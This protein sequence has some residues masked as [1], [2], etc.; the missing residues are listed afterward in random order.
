[1][2]YSR[3]PDPFR[4][5]RAG[6]LYGSLIAESLSLGVHWIYDPAEIVRRHG[7]VTDFIAPGADSYHPKKQAG[8]Q[9]H[10]GDQVLRLM[11]FLHR[12]QHWNA[13]NFL[14]DWRA[15]W[16]GYEDYFDKA[17]KATLANL[18][19]G[20][21]I[22]TCGSASDELAGPAR[23][24]PLAAFSVGDDET[25]LLTAAIEQTMLTHH[26]ADAVE[27]AEFLAHACHALL[28]GEPLTDAVLRLAPAWARAAVEKAIAMESVEAIGL[29]GRSC[30]IQSALPSVI[31]LVLRHGRDLETAFIENA[32]AGGDNCARGLALGMLLGAAHGVDAIPERWRMGLKAAA[33]VEAFLDRR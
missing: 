22:A 1:M 12:D 19:A 30:G 25:A 3:P 27:T 8:D 7:R 29:L 28:H 2:P 21:T 33:E 20:A 13:A 11:R 4:P 14:P 24:A 32:M 17:T 15:M 18:E 31:H 9:G 16:A 10:V 26:S 6:L 5:R 23:I